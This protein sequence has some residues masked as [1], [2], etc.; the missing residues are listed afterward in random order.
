MHIPFLGMVKSKFLANLPVDHLADPV[1][2]SH[3]FCANLQHS[4]IMLL[5]VSSLSPHSLDLLF[6]CILSIL[7]LI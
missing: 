4:L 6:C 5:M 2:T 7:A 3:S 1:V